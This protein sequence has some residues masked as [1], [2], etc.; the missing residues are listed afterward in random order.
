[1]S[2]SF[3]AAEL[4]RYV[5][6]R[7]DFLSWERHDRRLWSTAEP[8]C[9]CPEMSGRKAESRGHVNSPTMRDC[10]RYLCCCV[11]W[12]RRSIKRMENGDGSCSATSLSDFITGQIPIHL[13]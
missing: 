4:I 8:S 5:H 3:D 10:Q 9:P 2:P 13:S 7:D 1:M 6:P 11:E 12:C